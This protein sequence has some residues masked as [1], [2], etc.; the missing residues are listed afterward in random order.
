[1][2]LSRPLLL[3]Y[4][5]SIGS[6][7]AAILRTLGVEYAGVDE[8]DPAP[9]SFD[10]VIIATP[11]PLHAEHLAQCAR[12]GVPIMVEKPLATSLPFALE[13]CDLLDTER[14]KVRMV[15]QYRH[16]PDEGEE[17][18]TT[19]DYYRSGKDGLKW[20]AISLVALARGKVTLKQE[21]P[22]WRCRLNGVLVTYPMIE[23]AYVDM[24]Q[25]FLRNPP[26]KP[27]TGYMRAAHR[28][29]AEL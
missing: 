6:R 7:Y 24:I 11:T 23:N 9:A 3:G 12:Y 15:N 25:D 26:T 27:E 14:V 5:G 28:K 18:E 21:S 16:L 2:T 20:D 17:G 10:S 13:I 8:G 4:K 22:V 19:Y 29:V 1:M